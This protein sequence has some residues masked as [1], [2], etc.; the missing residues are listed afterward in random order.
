VRVTDEDARI[1]RTLCQALCWAGVA[2]SLWVLA[3]KLWLW[4]P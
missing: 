4:Q 1:V 3:Y 2:A